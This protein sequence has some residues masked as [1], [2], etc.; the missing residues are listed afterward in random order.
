MGGPSGAP[1]PPLERELEHAVRLA[2]NVAKNKNANGLE[3]VGKQRREGRFMGSLSSGE[4]SSGERSVR[5]NAKR[6]KV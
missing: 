2:A 5:V 1:V 3:R 4:R 6:I